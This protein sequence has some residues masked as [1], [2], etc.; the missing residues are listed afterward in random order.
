M[1]AITFDHVDK[2]FGARRVLDDVSCSVAEGER[3]AI[4]GRSG[5]GK[6]TFLHIAAGIETASSGR[7]S[8]F[9]KA[10]GE[11]PD[12]ERTLLRRDTIGLVFQFFH[13]LPHLT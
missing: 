3:I 11:L 9:G 6:S 10:L 8:V 2:M 13:L 1:S 5:S 12:R 7:V 4:I